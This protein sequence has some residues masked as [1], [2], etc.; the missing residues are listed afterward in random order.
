MGEYINDGPATIKPGGIIPLQSVE[1]FGGGCQT[2]H[3]D[4][5]GLVTLKSSQNAPR[6]F[7]VWYGGNL[8]IPDGGDPG[9]LEISVCINGE[10]LASASA[11]T[12]VNGPGVFRNVSAAVFVLVPCG[13]CVTVSVMN[14]SG[15]TIRAENNNLIIQ[16]I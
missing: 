7:S 4:G 14:T 2:T 9:D 10:P 5:S 11:K 1:N 15:Q 12:T 3:R 13:C 16:L 6:K 8:S